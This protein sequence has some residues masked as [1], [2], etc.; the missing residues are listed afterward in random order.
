VREPC[1]ADDDAIATIDLVVRL[2]ASPRIVEQFVRAA[3]NAAEGAAENAAGPDADSWFYAGLAAWS[4]MDVTAH[5]LRKH[6]LLTSALD[7]LSAAV[8]VRPDHWPAR[9]MR[10][11]YLTMLHSDEADEMVAFLLP[12]SY[13]MAGA[14]EDARTLVDLQAAAAPRAP[15]G[16]ATYCLAAVQ[17]LMVGDEPAAWRALW[18]GLSCT[19]AGPAPAMAAQIAVPVVIAVQRPE[20][21]GQPVLRAELTRRCRSL[22]RP[23]ER[24]A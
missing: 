17:S 11:S 24:V 21:E 8:S 23:G 3:E 13:G 2:N 22:T 18:T 9:F 10:A 12:G 15:Y 20:L 6:S 1:R 16:L 19:D 5:S 7:H 4:L 14:R